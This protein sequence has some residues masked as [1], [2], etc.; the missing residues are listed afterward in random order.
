MSITFGE[1]TVT[2][3]FTDKKKPELLKGQKRQPTKA[4]GTSQHKLRRARQPPS[5]SVK[6]KISWQKL[7]FVTMSVRS[8]I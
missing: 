1:V 3:F 4:S 7:R 6:K 2:C 5:L 8:R